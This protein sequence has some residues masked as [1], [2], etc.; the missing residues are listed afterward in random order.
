MNQAA[1]VAG[2]QQVAAGFQIIY[3]QL[4][5]DLPKVAVRALYPE[6]ECYD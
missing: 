2:Q 6:K 1:L 5:R 4:I 3:D